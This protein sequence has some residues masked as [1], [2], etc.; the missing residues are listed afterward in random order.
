MTDFC[1]LFSGA[2][3][4]TMTLS[5]GA[6]SSADAQAQES[7]LDSCSGSYICVVDGDVLDTSLTKTGAGRCFLGNLELTR[8]GTSLGADGREYSWSGDVSR[9]EICQ[10]AYCFSCYPDEPSSNGRSA[11]GRSS[12]SAP[13]SR[14]S[15]PSP[16]GAASNGSAL[17]P[18]ANGTASGGTS[19][20]ESEPASGGSPSAPR[21]SAPGASGGDAPS[22]GGASP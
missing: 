4:L 19:S 9:I 16:S 1:R 20:D 21:G 8:Q 11:A 7:P 3:L 13:G 17:T 2:A 15:G 14:L 18:P 22:A 10:A 12:S 6:C 5:L